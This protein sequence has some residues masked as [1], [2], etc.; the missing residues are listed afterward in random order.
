MSEVEKMIETFKSSKEGLLQSCQE[1]LRCAQNLMRDYAREEG[2]N[3]M[4]SELE[5]A[6]DLLSKVDSNIDLVV[7]LLTDEERHCTV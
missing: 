4:P 2:L 5:L 7:E 1:Y 6:T 3:K